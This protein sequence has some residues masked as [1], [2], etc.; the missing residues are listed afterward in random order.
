MSPA[1]T[2][3][4]FEFLLLLGAVACGSPPEPLPP[5]SAPP[6]LPE[7]AP[8]V[9]RPPT[10]S[11]GTPYLWKNVVILGGGFV[12]G[13]VFS[14]VQA[15]LAY[16][17][18]DVGGAY[19]LNP[20]KT[21]T[22][23]T[24]HFG[25]ADSNLAGVESIAPDPVDANVVYAAVGTYTQDWAGKGAILRS[26]NR[27]IDW[28]RTDMPIK[29]GGNENGRSNG[30][31]LAVDPN[32]P[33]TLYFGSRKDGLWK[34]TDGAVSFVKV[35][36]FPVKEDKSG[37][38]IPFIVFDAKSGTKGAPTPKIYVGVSNT[39][40]NL[41]ESTDAG[42][43]FTPVKKSPTGMMPSHAAFDA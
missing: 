17:R 29:M 30:E 43:T 5:P 28:K 14:P 1:K 13:V 15:G 25:R 18:T 24:D 37:L 16:A 33:N 21:W 23:L 19:R 32:Q 35:E 22:A 31:R 2:A 6:V 36:S 12:S 9:T 10:S 20:D 39:E 3:S 11:A 7:P 38:G 42:A 8:N 40:Q 34:S 26:N 27:G 41:Y 4:T